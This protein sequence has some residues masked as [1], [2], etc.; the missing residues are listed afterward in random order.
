MVSNNLE[1][2]DSFHHANVDFP[3]LKQH[4]IDELLKGIYRRYYIR[5]AYL[6]RMAKRSL[7]SWANTKQLMRLLGAYY[8]RWRKGWL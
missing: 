2:G 7:K 4:Q 1:N 5:P 3:N 8:I 6:L